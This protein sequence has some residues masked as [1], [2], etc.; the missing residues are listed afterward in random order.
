MRRAASLRKG[1][2]TQKNLSQSVIN[3]SRNYHLWRP[4][5]WAQQCNQ[6]PCKCP[7][8]GLLH[9]ENLRKFN[10]KHKNGSFKSL[11]DALDEET[12]RKIIVEAALDRGKTGDVQNY[13]KLER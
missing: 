10:K 1:R 9:Q 7:G 4:L 2:S 12:L 8:T 13:S 11:I 5:P 3:N 6:R